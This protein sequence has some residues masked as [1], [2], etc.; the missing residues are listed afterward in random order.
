M[1]EYKSLHVVV[2]ICVIIIKTHRHTQAYR[3]LPSCEEVQNCTLQLV[4]PH[5]FPQPH[6]NTFLH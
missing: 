1:Q 6:N 3:F 4:E 2:M 5:N